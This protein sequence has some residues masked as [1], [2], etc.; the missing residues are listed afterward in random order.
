VHV[1]VPQGLVLSP[2][3]FNFF[4][5]DFT[6]PS[7]VLTSFADDFSVAASRPNLQV[8]EEALN[9][10]MVNIAAWAARKKLSISADKSEVTLF[11][12]HTKEFNDKPRENPSQQ[13]S[14]LALYSQ[15]SHGP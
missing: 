15:G 5:S 8:I 12:P 7:Q 9:A 6:V 14:W 2:A 1:G 4:V 11:T 3:L 10:D 13:G